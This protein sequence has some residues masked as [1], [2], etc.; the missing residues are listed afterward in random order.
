MINYI[1]NKTILRSIICIVLTINISCKNSDPKKDKLVSK[2]GMVFIPGGN[3]DMGGDNEE[4]RSDEFP[5]HQVTVSSFWM[6][7]AEVTNAQFKKFVD[8]TGYTTTAER[9]IDW[10]EISIM[11]PPDTPKPH[12]SLLSPASL[13][14]KE[15]STSNLNDYSKW[16]SLVKGANWKQ[17]FG[18]GSDI[19]GK[20][21]F[22]VVH[23]SWE[24]A[25][26]YC[27]WSGKRLPTEAEFEFASRAGKIN[28]VYTWG[29]EKVDN[30]VLKANTWDGEF[31]KK[32]TIKDKFYYAAPVKSFKPN[33][34]GLYDLA[35]NVWEWCS[36]WYHA[37]YYSMLP[38]QG[39]V[40]P[41]GPDS[42]YDPVEPF[43]EKKV[44]RG[45]SF[46]CNDSYCSG[47]RNSARM[48]TTPDSSSL[49]TGFRTVVSAD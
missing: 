2:E 11:L 37:N 39:S 32:N 35:G 36:D 27:E 17:P 22:P 15:V 20:E 45:G 16:W 9:K 34:Y 26:A 12:D 46:L 47:Y 29:N 14:F 13:V 19:I 8:E 10:D 38:K 21:N 25:N 33:N 42:S 41:T 30:G 48:K 5:K 18:P 40:D 7:I 23:V 44:I 31:P 6:D 49:H 1:G 43:S 24:D 3:F 28:S 4:A